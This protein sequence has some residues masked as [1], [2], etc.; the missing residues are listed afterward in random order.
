MPALVFW[1]LPRTVVSAYLDL[2]DG[3]N[4]RVAGI[5]VTFLAIAAVFQLFDGVQIIAAAVLR[6]LKDTRMP[7]VIALI[8]YWPLG[9]GVCLLL[10]FP[11]GLSGE[12]IWLG[13]ALGLLVVACLLIWRFHRRERFWSGPTEL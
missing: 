2:D 8:G 11:L 7:L 12:G 9:F 1:L 4:L 13:F 3:E 10:A 6:G 5:A